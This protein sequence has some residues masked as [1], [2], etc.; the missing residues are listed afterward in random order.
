[1]LKWLTLEK[2]K[3]QCH[4]E[5]DYIEEDDLLVLY[6]ESAEESILNIT[7]RTYED[8]IETFG[9]VP[10][11][12]RLASLLMVAGSYE[13]REPW[14]QQKLEQTPSFS[15]MVKPYVRLV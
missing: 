6:G 12:L 13:I 1:M 15:I 9:D 11:S 3:A 8:I 4:L 2:I 5:Q 14:T 7:N 10:A